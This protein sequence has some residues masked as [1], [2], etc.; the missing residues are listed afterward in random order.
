MAE[1]SSGP[2]KTFSIGFTHERFN[3]LP[4]ARTVAEHFGTDH[5]ELIVEPDALEI[6]P[7]M[8]RHYGEPFADLAALPSFYLAEMARRHVTVALNGDGGDEAFAGYPRYVANKVLSDAARLPP[9]RCA[10]PGRPVRAAA[11]ERPQRLLGQRARRFATR[12]PWT[13]RAGTWPT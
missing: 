7:R 1:A 2:V 13:S 9:R 6:I 8:V 10:R 3:E 11:G 12:C 4:L 5:H